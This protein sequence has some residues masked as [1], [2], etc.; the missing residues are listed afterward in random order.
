MLA[1]LL[2][3]RLLNPILDAALLRIGI[4]PILTIDR[5]CRVDT[6]LRQEE[7]RLSCRIAAAY[8]QRPFLYPRIRLAK[9]IEHMRQI[10]ARHVE[11]PRI[12]HRTDSEENVRGLVLAFVRGDHKAPLL[13]KE[14][15]GFSR[16]V[17]LCMI[18]HG[19]ENHLV[20]PDKRHRDCHPSFVRRGAR[21]DA[22]NLFFC[23]NIQLVIKDEADVIRKQFLA[24]RFLA[25]RITSVAYSPRLE[26]TIAL[27]YVRYDYL[28]AGTELKVGD[29][30][31]TVTELPFIK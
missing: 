27:A 31:T 8:D 7:R 6:L 26:R 17:V 18:I 20:S 21:F 14:G 15:C 29:T 23:V 1:E 4:L 24:C 12:I 2:L 16:G 30:P 13:T 19:G 10:L 28:A 25:G 5:E 11:L 9:M 3:E 22:L